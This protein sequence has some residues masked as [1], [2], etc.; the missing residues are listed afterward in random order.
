[1]GDGLSQKTRYLAPCPATS[2]R[3]SFSLRT[4]AATCFIC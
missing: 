4:F 1:M 3:T 2:R